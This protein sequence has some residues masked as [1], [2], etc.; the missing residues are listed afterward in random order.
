MKYTIY[1]HN[2]QK[3]FIEGVHLETALEDANIP[4]EAMM[5]YRYDHVPND[6]DE[7]I[8]FPENENEH[9]VREGQWV[10]KKAIVFPNIPFKDKE[11]LN[12]HK[13]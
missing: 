1:M 9:W 12:T 4:P 11:L 13:D 6:K 10:H 7:F 5:E 8:W 2:G 3:V